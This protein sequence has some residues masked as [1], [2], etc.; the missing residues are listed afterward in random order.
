MHTLMQDAS[1]SDF[2]RLNTIDQHMRADEEHS[3]AFAQVD[4]SRPYFRVL[5]QQLQGGIQLVP[6]AHQLL[7]APGLPGMAKDVDKVPARSGR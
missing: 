3:V 5:A 6:V 2:L 7:F 1:D 4:L